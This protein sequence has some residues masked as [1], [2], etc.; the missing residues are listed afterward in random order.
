MIKTLQGITDL[1]EVFRLVD[2]DDYDNIDKTIPKRRQDR[3]INIED[4]DKDEEF[5]LFDDNVFNA[6]RERSK[7]DNNYTNDLLKNI[8]K[9]IDNKITQEQ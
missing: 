4:V 8:N 3:P 1:K 5:N 6:I 9:E 7:N 2:Y